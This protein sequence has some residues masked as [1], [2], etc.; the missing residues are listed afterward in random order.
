[1]WTGWYGH[2]GLLL[3]RES[4]AAVGTLV[5]SLGALAGAI[6]YVLFSAM[7]PSHLAVYPP[8]ACLLSFALSVLS[9]WLSFPYHPLSPLIPP[10][11]FAPRHTS[12]S[13]HRCC[14]TSMLVAICI[15][16]ES[17]ST[18]LYVSYV[19]VWLS[20]VVTRHLSVCCLFRC[21][22]SLCCIDV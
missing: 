10:S 16:A 1:M 12:S 5:P 4:T 22:L 17:S 15:S 9:I 8:S 6:A 13:L 2:P 14:V 19:K 21:L 18:G 3:D 20:A 7:T 11:S